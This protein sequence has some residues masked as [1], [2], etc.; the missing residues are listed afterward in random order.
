MDFKYNG[1]TYEIIVEKK[2]NKNTYI[3]VKDDLKI[4]VSTSFLTPKI[5]IKNLIENNRES[6]IKMINLQ[7]KKQSKKDGYYFLGQ[8]IDI[9]KSNIKRPYLEDDILYINSKDDITKWYNKQ[10][11]KVFKERLD[12]IYNTFTEDI[13]YP[14]LIIRSMKTRWG[15]CNKNLEKVTLNYNL[16]YM[17]RKYLDYVIVHELS[18]FIHFDHSKEF[19]KLVS[20]NE[21][22]YKQIR[23]EMR[24]C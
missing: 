11:K 4:Y 20:Q 22:N 1:K 8:R 6:I 24:E 18:H 3:R 9:V 2:N 13:P 14:K 16:I 10:A 17:D 23:K 12:T 15:V 5:V 19:W 21:P 7:E